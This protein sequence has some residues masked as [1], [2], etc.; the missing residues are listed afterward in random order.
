[1]VTRAGTGPTGCATACSN[2]L[3]AA[4]A[5]WRTV[6][7]TSIMRRCA[8]LLLS[9]IK[10]LPAGLSS[11][12]RRS[13]RSWRYSAGRPSSIPAIVP[14]RSPVHIFSTPR[15]R[16][17]RSCTVAAIVARCSAELPPAHE[18]S[19]LMIAASLR[20]ALRSQLWPCMHPW[21]LRRPAM[22][23][24]T[25]T[26]P[27][28]SGDTRHRRAP[29][30]PPR[31]P[32]CRATGRADPCRSCP[33]RGW[34]CRWG[35]SRSPPPAPG[36]VAR[37]RM[38][39]R[40][41]PKCSQ[42]ASPPPS[43]RC[44]APR[45]RR[46]GPARRHSVGRAGH[47]VSLEGLGRQAV[48]VATATRRPGRAPRRRPR[49]GRRRRH[50]LA[51]PRDLG[52]PRPSRAAGPRARSRTRRGRGRGAPTR[53]RRRRPAGGRPRSSPR[54]TVGPVLTPVPA[55]R[56]RS[57]PGRPRPGAAPAT[58]SSISRPRRW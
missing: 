55:R 36:A 18:L 13:C 8:Q 4:A 17:G 11:A 27:S 49:P 7:P 19:T 28:S 20:P 45:H 31:R 5:I 21:S 15:A 57:A 56:R 6:A 26:S 58:P 42:R 34:R 43:R 22:A 23:L 51:R 38:R 50:R 41:S 39:S 37:R 47:Q 25:M 48:E 12:W 32:W 3:T 10:M 1:M 9:P 35:S 30:V 33:S 54:T 29:R 53:R 14:A 16:T 2:A 24:P 40:R 44:G 52:R 46:S